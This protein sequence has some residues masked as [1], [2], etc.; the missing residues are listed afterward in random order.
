MGADDRARLAVWVAY[1][2]EVALR[3]KSFRVS[4]AEIARPDAGM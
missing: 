3:E 4:T 2:S 1:D